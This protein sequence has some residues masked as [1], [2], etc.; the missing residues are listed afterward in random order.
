MHSAFGANGGVQLLVLGNGS[1][2]HSLP[3]D[4]WCHVNKHGYICSYFPAYFYA[5][6]ACF[7]N[8]FTPT[9]A[10]WQLPLEREGE[11]SQRRIHSGR[12]CHARCPTPSSLGPRTWLPS[13]MESVLVWQQ[14]N[15]TL[16]PARSLPKEVPLKEQRCIV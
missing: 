8:V 2:G 7:E 6:H 16:K 10:C 11:T 15:S 12:S 1:Q 3:K 5:K 14:Q 9:H 13:A 4:Y